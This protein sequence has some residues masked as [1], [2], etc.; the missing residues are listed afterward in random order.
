[1][2]PLKAFLTQLEA[3]VEYVA[4]GGDPRLLEGCLNIVLTGNPGAG[5]TTAARLLA[6]WLRAHGLLQQAS[7]P[8]AFPCLAL[9]R[10]ALSWP[11]QASP[12]A[13]PP[14]HTLFTCR[15]RPL[16]PS[17]RLRRAERPRAQGDAHRMDVPAG[18]GE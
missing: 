1:M 4:R 8:L 17:G 18:Q 7:L 5:K 14:S 6:R 2:A 3:K 15:L 13:L 12:Q 16:P 10:F 9:P 11:V